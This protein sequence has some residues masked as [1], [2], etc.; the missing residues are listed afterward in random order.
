LL[1]LALFSLWVLS[2]KSVKKY[3]L[4]D[5]KTSYNN[6]IIQLSTRTFSK[7]SSL[8]LNCIKRLLF[9]KWKTKMEAI[10]DKESNQIRMSIRRWNKYKK[11]LL[12]LLNN[13]SRIIKCLYSKR[14]KSTKNNSTMS[15]KEKYRWKKQCL[16]L[17]FPLFSKKHLLYSTTP[18]Q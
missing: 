18:R 4:V 5:I 3:F 17:L 1:F 6:I 14:N 7:S 13:N 8:N 15:T 10:R 11:V 9:G 2:K 16:R 12:F